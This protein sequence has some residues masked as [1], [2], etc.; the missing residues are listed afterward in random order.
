MT[1]YALW[2]KLR[3]FYGRTIS[4]SCAISGV[5]AL[6]TIEIN[7]PRLCRSMCGKASPF[8]KDCPYVCG[9]AKPRRNFNCAGPEGH[10]PSAHQ[11]AE[12]C[13]TSSTQNKTPPR[14]RCRREPEREG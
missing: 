5:G 8:R 2:T 6:N 14:H 13:L 11:T 9:E 4:R 10:R 1:E 7:N 12:S 3:R